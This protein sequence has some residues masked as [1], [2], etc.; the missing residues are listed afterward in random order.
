METASFN[1][2]P[3]QKPSMDDRISILTDGELDENEA[4]QIITMA[5]RSESAQEQWAVYHLIGD[6]LRDSPAGVS[7]DFM[8]RF[9]ARL[10]EEPTVLAPRQR[11]PRHAL[12][13]LS[14]AASVAVVTGIGLLVYNN[15]QII[16]SAWSWQPD[17]AHHVIRENVSPYLLAHQE[18]AP[19][20]RPG[21]SGN[22]QTVSFEQQEPAR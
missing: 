22:I 10:A 11:K 15:D 2:Q 19:G 17:S 12:R 21:P 5:T 1:I 9:S 13:M 20:S 6:T 8:A 18:F 4:S 14:A 3:E 16:D 7:P